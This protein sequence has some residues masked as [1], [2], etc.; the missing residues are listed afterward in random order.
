MN[1]GAAVWTKAG[2]G[3]SEGDIDIYPGEN[4]NRR[5]N[6]RVNRRGPRGK[7][8]IFLSCSIPNGTTSRFFHRAM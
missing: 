5:V 8:M 2:D 6:R 7:V 3:G 1:E 4:E